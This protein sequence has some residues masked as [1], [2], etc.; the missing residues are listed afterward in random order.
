[1]A[2]G[3]RSAEEANSPLLR[4]VTGASDGDML[5]RVPLTAAKFTVAAAHG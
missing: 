1:M 5:V 3:S 2:A 4:A